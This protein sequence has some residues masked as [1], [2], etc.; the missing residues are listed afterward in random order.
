M[1]VSVALTLGVGLLHGCSR[2]PRYEGGVEA[3]H[4]DGVRFS[5]TVPADKSIFDIIGLIST[6][7]LHKEPWPKWVENQ[8]YQ[9][10]ENVPDAIVV[11][12]INHSTVLLR[13]NGLNVL[14]DPMWSERASPFSFAGPKRVRHPG[15]T[16]EELP[17][18]D[19]ILI[20]HDHYDHLDVGALRQL[21]ARGRDGSPLVLAGLGTGELLRS[22]GISRIRELDWGEAVDVQEMRVSFVEVR[23]RSGRGLSDQMKTLWGGFVIESKA[24]DVYFAGD[25]GY[26]PHFAETQARFGAFD[27]A[28]IP[29]GAYRPRSFM[30]PVHLDPQ[31]AVRAHQDLHATQSVAIHHG[32]FQLTYEG[33]DEPY[34]ELSKA[35][36]S[37]NLPPDRFRVLGF[38]ES[39]VVRP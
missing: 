18:I 30:A 22:A 21:A 33:I 5:N 23:H 7:W 1:A 31:F 34:Q 25:T 24:G 36:A 29:I 20:S 38:G 27:L 4:F 10:A 32:T 15:M 2:T 8:D 16:I 39:L 12:F 19:L 35:L 26:G 13:I 9:P 17:P 6:F 3:A 11:T 14:T 28:L 37:A